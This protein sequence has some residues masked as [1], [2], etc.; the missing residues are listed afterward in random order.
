MMGT[1]HLTIG[2]TVTAVTLLWA[3]IEPAS[4]PFAIGLGIGA[5]ASLLPDIDGDPRNA[6]DPL[7]RRILQVGNTQSKRQLAHA[8][9]RGHLVAVLWNLVLR[10][11]ALIINLIAATLPHRGVTHWGITC[12][13]LTAVFGMLCSLLGWPLVYTACFGVGYASHIAA[14]MTTHSGVRVLGGLTRNGRA[15]HLLPKPLRIRTGS[16]SEWVLLAAI[17]VFAT[18]WL[19]WGSV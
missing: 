10:S 5:L 14:D 19:L 7:I 6:A 17:E 3:G 8:F 11:V 12:L 16:P 18:V 9:R 4:P 2:T 1:S 15:Y 13:L